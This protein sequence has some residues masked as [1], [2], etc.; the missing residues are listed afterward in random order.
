MR[1]G[2][3]RPGRRADRRLRAVPTGQGLRDQA[4]QRSHGAAA[5]RSAGRQHDRRR[6]PPRPRPRRPPARVHTGD[7]RTAAQRK[8]HPTGRAEAGGRRSHDRRVVDHALGHSRRPHH[9]DQ[10]RRRHVHPEQRGPIRARLWHALRSGKPLRDGADRCRDRVERRVPV[11]GRPVPQGHQLPRPRVGTVPR[12]PA[13]RGPAARRPH[14][15][16]ARR[17][18]VPRHLQLRLLVERRNR[19]AGHD[20][21]PACG[22]RELERVRHHGA[23]RQPEPDGQP[24]RAAQR[25]VRRG[26]QLLR[27]KLRHP[28]DAVPRRDRSPPTRRRPSRLPAPERMPALVARRHPTRL[29]ADDRRHA[30]TRAPP[31]RQHSGRPEDPQSRDRPGRRGADAAAPGLPER[32]GRP[33]AGGR[34]QHRHAGPDPDLPRRLPGLDRE[35]EHRRAAQPRSR[36]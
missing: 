2:G 29:R 18:P 34:E 26:R 25:R 22:P 1:T 7:T 6:V 33:L 28:H 8:H 16:A 3:R 27:G 13:R 24:R 36:S 23:A 12:L 31:L 11:P 30:P 5:R 21:A 9:H 15:P 20:H 14:V 35:R 32:V 4:R 19:A 10:G 17:R